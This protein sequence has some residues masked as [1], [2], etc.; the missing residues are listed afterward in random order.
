MADP[1]GVEKTAEVPVA[2]L[3]PERWVMLAKERARGRSEELRALASRTDSGDQLSPD[4][5]AK[6]RDA[7]SDPQAAPEA[8]LAMTTLPGTAG[9]DLIYEVTRDERL[10]AET[11]QLASDLLG[12]KAVQANVS[13]ALRVVMD[14]SRVRTCE[15]VEPVLA[16]VLEV[17]DRRALAGLRSLYSTRGCGP[18]KADDCYPCLRQSA[19]LNRS[20]EAVR[21]RRPPW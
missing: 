4:T 7:V 20:A 15:E 14:L 9:A 8:L 6:L 1:I 10:S 17:G 21:K 13:E 19:L 11:R 5:V 12:T 16:R 3:T 18:R 2:E